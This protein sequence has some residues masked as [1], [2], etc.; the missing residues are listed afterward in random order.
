V[1][2]TGL[3]RKRK[4]KSGGLESQGRGRLGLEDP[5]PQ[6]YPES[7]FHGKIQAAGNTVLMETEFFRE[8]TYPAEPFQTFF[9]LNCVISGGLRMIRCR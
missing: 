4:P 8:N 5:V 2:N 9:E 6:T 3:G 7:V 1:D